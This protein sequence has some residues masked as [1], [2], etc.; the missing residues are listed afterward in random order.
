MKQAKTARRT[1]KSAFT[2]IG[3]ALSH[4]VAHN[5][6]ASEVR[7][8]I[9]KLKGAY[10][11]LVDKHEEYAKHIEEDEAYEKEEEWLTNCQETFMRLEVDAKMFIESLEKSVSSDLDGNQDLSKGK[12][13]API[14][15]VG[16]VHQNEGIP[17]MQSE[18]PLVSE[19]S[20][21]PGMTNIHSDNQA[22]P[23]SDHGNAE[24]S[25]STADNKQINAVNDVNNTSPTDNTEQNTTPAGACTFKLEKPKLPV[26]TGN[27][28]DY[29][30][31]RSDFKH[32]IEAKY[33]KRDAITLLRTCLRDKPLELIKGIGSDYDAA[34]EYLDA[35]YGDPR[36]VS[37]TVTQDIVQFR[38]LQDGEDARFCDLVHLVKRCYNT[39]KDVGLP[40]DM[41]NSHMLSVIE[42]KMCAD[43]RKVWA[44]DLEKEKKPATLHALM[45]WMT[46]EMKSRMRAT[47]PIRITGS[48]RRLVNH[49][50]GNE[51]DRVWHKCWM[52]KNS[53]HWP[54]QCPKFAALSVD[55]R[56]ATAK[57]NHICFSC[58]KRAGRGHTAESCRR[59]QQCPKHENGMR[60]SQ[61][62]HQLL[63]KSNTVKISVASVANTKEAILPVLSV[64]IG[65]TDGLFKCGNV[66]LDSGAQVS[67]IRKETA[68]TLGLKGKDVSV[69]ITK[70]GG[71]EET[72]KTKEYKV[73]LICIDDNKRYTVKAISID[74]ISDEIPKVKT[75]HLPELLGLPNTSFRRG[76]GHVD[77]L[78]GIDHAHM[79]AGETKQADHLIAR[80]SPLG[81]VVFGGKA[82]Q[83][84]DASAILHVKYAS[85]IEM[86][87]FWKTEAMG[88]EI[89]P[90]VCDADKL[91][92]V[93]REEAEIIFNSCERVGKQ[94]MVPYPW[95][96]DPA[97]L[98]DNKPLAM[99]RL[100]ST[101]R[102]LKKEPEQGIAYDKQMEEMREMHFSRKLSKEEL[103]N[104]KGPVHY[105]PHHA[106]IRPEKK[107]TPVRIVFNSSSVYQ[108]HALNDYWLKGPDML[109]NLFGVILR[110]REREVAVM[111]DISKMYHRVL[112]P[113]RDQHVHRF[114]WRNLK[115]EREP[116][117][118]VKTVLTFG[119]KPAPA[120]A[121]TA[122]RKTAEENKNDYP[123]AAEAIT[124]NSYM[125]DIC[126]SVDTVTSAQKLTEDL[127]AV[128]ESG[129]FGVKGWTSNKVLTKTENRERGFKTF[130]G[131]VEEKVLGV[132]WN[133]VTDEFSF[134][135]K[136][137][138]TCPTDHSVPRGEKMTKRKLLSQVS[139]I[140][141]PIGFAA[142]FIIRAKIG[143][144]ELWQ[145]GLDWDD[146]LPCDIQ[147]RW[148]QLFKEM[149]EL[150]KIGFKR[151]LVSPETP[152]LPLLCVFS[153]ASQQ[154]F[155]ACAYIRQKTKQDT[156]E[157]TFV[158]A[159][160]RVAPLKQLTVPR[161]ELQAAV[162]AARLA[163]AIVQECRI[164]FEHVKF[165]TDSTI[166][167]A[168]IQSSSRGFKPFVSSRVGE[169]QSNS[170]P[171]QWR[172]IPSEEN[173][174]DDLSRGLHIQQLTGRW[175]KGPDF[176][177][178]PEEEWPVLTA[179][180][181]PK[182][183]MERRHVYAVGA[184]SHADVGNVIDPKTFSSW[185][186]LIR[187]TAWIRRLAEKIRAR[188]SK[189]SG[190]EGPLTPE[191]LL[192][193]EMS[194]IRSAQKSLQSRMKNGDFKTLSPFVDDKGIIRVGG[195]V[196]KATVTYEE[197]HPALLPH[198]HRIS[199]LITSHMHNYGHPGVATTTAKTRRKYWILRANKLSKTV[200]FKCVTC[201]RMAHKAEVQ[202]MA[203]LPSLRLAPQTP[204]F[205]YTA[206]D[207]FGPFTVKLGRNK[208][209]KHYGVIFTCL[210]TRAVHLEMAVDC[211][212]MEFIQV[213]RRFFSIRG[214][215]AVLLSDNG[216]Q[217]VGA[218][219]E[220]RQM[221]QG[222]DPNK[223]KDFCAERGI[224]WMFTTPAAPHQNGCA[225][226]LVK[227]C[228]GTLKKAIGE[229]VLTPFELYTCLLEVGNLVNQ[230]P[231]GRIPN[232][233][234]DGKY[235]CPN[236]MLL[237]RASSEVPQGPFTD[238][239]NPRRRVEFVQRIVDS[240]WKRWSRDV[241]PALVTRKKWRSKERNVRVN[242]VVVVADSNAIR[243]KWVVGRVLEVYPGA[244][245]YVRNVKVKT[246][247][248]EYS[249]P[250]TKIAVIHP[251]EGDE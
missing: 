166:T 169:I 173:V 59:N 30:I 236:D 122:L 230:R 108:G 73:Q 67:L 1:A 5:R 242:D 22:L 171:S 184:V 201:R 111:G 105:I 192:K 99:K 232:D 175:M 188:R 48:N 146:E 10:E 177:R 29:A 101:E 43:D 239:K 39:L 151:C 244:D 190:R 92:Q 130:Q 209:T 9:D 32:A 89:K 180:P 95:K 107:S 50:K 136:L 182:E 12:Q 115:T 87:D 102:R 114:L 127:N 198:D 141:D 200:K 202:L 85:P 40:S 218:A 167:L 113:E 83:L 35:I 246:Q 123:E 42:Q 49:L 165:F 153:D 118:Y 17:S 251:A 161:L 159:K 204:P 199:L 126:D 227:S 245:G 225:E 241:F 191:E 174:A 135:V 52:C 60:C 33:T 20:H 34:W 149:Q 51:N 157:V 4:A 247:A 3:K 7:E 68:E 90:C 154:A 44:R 119:D 137:E 2:R 193:A 210:N 41:D 131:D 13:S 24:Q 103:D 26:F 222:L 55:D 249:R 70:V 156:Y 176:L 97:L 6:P 197:K 53:S 211:T 238:T 129:G 63:H 170:D 248:G 79:H 144:Q 162:L 104:Y 185:R 158:A 61:H 160:S 65:S 237:G 235:L 195:R 223:L 54:D 217:M 221:V 74:S 233:P 8:A 72:M 66:L 47:A 78:I 116:D 213:L 86:S 121:Q 18:T 145:L 106:V 212:T 216:S 21:S 124:K 226:A 164:Q 134:K 75:S 143:M 183:D 80:K 69:T 224:Q 250:V 133:Y 96:K 46:V 25:S 243:G 152:E 234:D 71:E 240:F 205:Y 163:K 77:L 203:E 186:K 231:V 28:R 94:W 84:S 56:I 214:C 179:T 172:H 120:M 64:N 215:P 11:N 139:R 196:D 140:Y 148:T 93:E 228:K 36:F 100:E 81:W 117:V 168:W 125:D 88:V 27:V 132:V 45:T 208:R 23:A 219:R 76:K 91:T 181:Q 187:V 155:G 15:V 58:L 37:D 138:L 206:C 207:Y 38:A 62:H 194:W 178:L 189:L 98:P 229:Q 110:F 147:E 150:D 82:E 16:V 57:A 128:L 109:N 112:I 19:D 31:F 220:L 142:A 14:S